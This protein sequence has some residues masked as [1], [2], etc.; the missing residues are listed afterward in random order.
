MYCFYD[1]G[2][3]NHFD[4]YFAEIASA[5][6]YQTSRAGLSKCGA[7]LKA[8]L[9]GPTLWRMQNFFRMGIKSS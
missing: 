5:H 3:P 4:D 7:R 8:L 2:F 6:K 9:R 1:G